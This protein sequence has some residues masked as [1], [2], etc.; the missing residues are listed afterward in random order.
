MSGKISGQTLLNWL[1]KAKAGPIQ[2]KKEYVVVNDNVYATTL[3]VRAWPEDGAVVGFMRPYLDL[4]ARENPEMVI[5]LTYQFAPTALVFNQSLDLRR[6]RLNASIEAAIANKERPRQSEVNAVRTI[7]ALEDKKEDGSGN[8]V[9]ED[10]WCF[11]TLIASDLQK[12]QKVVKRLCDRFHNDGMKLHKLPYEQTTGF[13]QSWILASPSLPDPD[14]FYKNRGRL[15]DDDAAATLYPASFGNMSDGTG[16]YFGH[17]II[18]G[19]VGPPTYRRHGEGTEDGNILVA[20]A[21]GQGKSTLLKGLATGLIYEGHRDFV[22]DVDGEWE[23]WCKT[24]GGVWVNQSGSSG[25]YMDPLWVPPPLGKEDYDAERLDRCSSSLLS[26]VSLLVEGP[27]RKYAMEPAEM[28]A[29]EKALMR[30][31]ERKGIVREDPG[32]WR[33]E[34]CRIKEWYDELKTD[35]SPEAVALA[36][37]VWGYFEGLRASIFNREDDPEVLDNANIIVLH[38]SQSIDNEVDAHTGAVKM[39][40]AQNTV[41]HQVVK[42]R[43]RKKIYTNVFYD[44][45]QRIL[46]N[47]QASSNVNKLSTAIRKYNGNLIFATNKPSSLWDTEGGNGLW[48]NSGYKILLWLEESDLKKI[49]EKADIPD[50]ILQMV[51]RLK[52]S[53]QY[54]LRGDIRQKIT[55]DR[56]KMMLPPSELA[57]Y[58]T[59]GL[60]N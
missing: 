12:L 31:W 56:L 20:G 52:G 8:L 33:T 42:E 29:A 60:A 27:E 26:I 18:N 34:R 36:N 38:V 32:T 50:H 35:S 1:E 43:M 51:G 55:Y 47:Q 17:R 40:L 6:K 16:A 46:M 4:V 54:I 24:M 57:L 14:F 10:I 58:E 13:L 44:E 49:K 28:N 45:G 48:S 41:W 15:V 25:R 3:M 5:R 11:I 39:Q 53:N 21:T 37:K 59:R 22:F 2:R 19:Y 9:T 23:P 7:N 30:L